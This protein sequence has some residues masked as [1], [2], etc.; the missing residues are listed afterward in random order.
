M[1]AVLAEAQ[2]HTAGTAKR[3]I[4]PSKRKELLASA[5]EDAQ[6][7]ANKGQEAADKAVKKA[8]K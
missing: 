1:L 8:T 6:K 7:L 4:K 3:G 5:R 2:C